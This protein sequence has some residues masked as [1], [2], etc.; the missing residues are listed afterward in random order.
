MIVTVLNGTQLGI[1]NR[2]L[3]RDRSRF[4]LFDEI[5]ELAFRID[6]LHSSVQQ[7]EEQP[8]GLR[9]QIGILGYFPYHH[10]AL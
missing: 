2:G 4:V 10:V 9:T 8:E 6:F 3:C 7:V 5:P 1:E